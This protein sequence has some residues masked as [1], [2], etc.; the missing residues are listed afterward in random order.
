MNMVDENEMA[1]HLNGEAFD[2]VVGGWV[3]RLVGWVFTR[4]EVRGAVSLETYDSYEGKWWE[5]FVK[6]GYARFKRLPFSYILLRNLSIS[7]ND[8]SKVIKVFVNEISNLLF[9]LFFKVEIFL[10]L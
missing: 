7:T 2:G 9:E 8:I 6:G 3:G 4:V 5:L 10:S 1:R